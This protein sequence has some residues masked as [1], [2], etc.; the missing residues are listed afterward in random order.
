M[1]KISVMI[2][3]DEKLVLEDL[4]TIIDW[5]ELGFEIVAT[6]MNGKQA[7][8][9]YEQYHPQVVFTDI[10][11][12][13]MDGIEL[14]KHLRKIDA[15]AQIL[16]LT[17]Y[18]DFSYAKS[19]IQYDILDYIIK[20]TINSQTFLSLLNRIRIVI[21]NQGK[22]L[23]ILK[24]K[25]IEDYFVTN[26]E[27][28]QMEDK[29]LFTTP[30]CYLIVEQDMPI[31][32]SGDNSIEMIRYQKADVATILLE[33]DHEGY[34]IVACSNTPR[35]QLILL[36]DIPGTSKA[37]FNQTLFVYAMNKKILLKE[38]LNLDFTFYM[39]SNK[40]NLLELKRLYSIYSHSFYDKYLMEKKMVIDFTD[41][42][43]LSVLDAEE[44]SL[45]ME[46]MRNLLEK[47]D[48][49]EL[50]AYIEILFRDICTSGSYKS[51][52]SVSRELYDLLKRNNKHLPEYSK[53]LNLSLS[54][55]WR[56]WLSAKLLYEWFLEN[57]LDLIHEKQKEEQNKFSKPVV[58][59]MDFIFQNYPNVE[60]G[61]NDIADY[62]NLSTGHLCVLFKKETGK[63]L[64]NYISEVRIAEAKRLLD[65]K[66]FKVKKISE[67]VGFQS[68][69]YFSQVFYKLVGVTPNEY[70]KGK[71]QTQVV[72]SEC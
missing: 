61:I 66:Q 21:D 57:F 1:K 71:R 47:W 9:K 3:D 2:V 41:Y 72:V 27:L 33:G 31:N 35:E 50:K 48:E 24:G 63:T 17:A 69:Q 28:D 39:V 38:R 26:R 46:Y 64:N 68:S 42:R 52:C 45:D 30:Y 67:A 13:F 19:A 62:V 53:K 10:K 34:E 44:V 4:L 49:Q 12:P 70:R 36:F 14:I 60:L 22:V 56:N 23:D 58:K 65:E 40:V 6:A 18:E 25:R 8:S 11:M 29:E 54:D 59:A 43:N 7:L 51:L 20:S 15:K 16:L 37:V 32:I 5:D 55:N